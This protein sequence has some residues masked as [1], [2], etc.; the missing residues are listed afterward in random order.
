MV[1]PALSLSEKVGWLCM[2]MGMEARIPMHSQVVYLAV[3][4]VHLP[5]PYG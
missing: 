2:E 1:L 3:T 5:L 4:H